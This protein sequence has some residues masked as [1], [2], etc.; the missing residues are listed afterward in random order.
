MGSSTPVASARVLSVRQASAPSTTMCVR[1]VNPSSVS[2]SAKSLPKR[3]LRECSEVQ[4]A[5]RSPVPASPM[6]VSAWPPQRTTRRLISAIP[7]VMSMAA[8]LSPNPIP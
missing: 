4:V 5:T 6:Q 8:V 1:S 2:P 7:R 3:R